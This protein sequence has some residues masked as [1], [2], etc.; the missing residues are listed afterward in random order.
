M[1]T[2]TPF[3]L[4]RDELSG[5]FSVGDCMEKT[6]GKHRVAEVESRL[7]DVLKAM[8]KSEEEGRNFSKLWGQLA[9][10][11][12]TIDTDAKLAGLECF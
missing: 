9:D 8:A 4:H 11:L 10:D 3:Q 6:I 12:R 7:G 2:A 1:L 5:I